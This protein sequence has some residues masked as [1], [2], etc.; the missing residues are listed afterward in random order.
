MEGYSNTILNSILR[1]FS[2][3]TKDYHF[4]PLTDGYINDTFMV[5]DDD[6]PLYIL[7]RVNHTVFRNMKGLMANIDNALDQLKDLSYTEIILVKTTGTKT[8]FENEKGYWRLMTFIDHSVAY[9][10]TTDPHTAFEAGRIIAKF[11]ILLQDTRTDD[12]VDT[13][14]RFHDLELRKEQFEMAL[15]SAN[16]EKKEIAKKAILFAQNV[17]VTLSELSKKELPVRVCHNDTKLNNILFSKKENKAL[18]LIDLD[19]LMK[20]HFY[21]DFGDA[22]RT[23]VNTAPED[24]QDHEKITFDKSLFEAFVNGLGSVGPFLSKQEIETLPLGASFMPFIHGLRALTDY[25]ND[26]IYYKVAY[27]NQ[28]LDRCLSLFDF[29]EKALNEKVYM[30]NMVLEKL[31]YKM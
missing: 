13:I 19:T 5:L 1:N 17:L 22:V 18:C 16:T 27:A 23:I 15:R 4:K 8:F 14:P 31:E 9:N 20:G 26:N 30:E 2:I 21:Y 6:R 10:T 29:A 11:H 28:N 25:L 7:Q 3:S 24:E 12:F